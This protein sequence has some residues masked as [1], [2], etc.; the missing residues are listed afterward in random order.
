MQGYG[1]LGPVNDNAPSREVIRAVSAE[2]PE[3]KS[4]QKRCGTRSAFMSM[5]DRRSLSRVRRVRVS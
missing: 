3:Q 5:N 2:A 4:R 1:Y